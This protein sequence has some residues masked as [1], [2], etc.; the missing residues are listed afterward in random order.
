MFTATQA[1][2]AN[3]VCAALSLVILLTR[4][5]V[6]R[7]RRRPLDLS[8]F[9][10]I[11][12]IATIISR[13]VVVYYYLLYG[14]AND[15]LHDDGYFSTHNLAKVKTGTI[16]SL[17]ARVIIT[18]TCWLQI[19]LLLLFYSHIMEGIRWVERMI[20]VTWIVVGATFLA[21]V[22]TTL[23][24]CRPLKLYWQIEPDPGTC[25]KGYVQLNV[26]CSGNVVLDLLL[27]GISYPILICKHRTWQQHLRV[28]TLFVLG[29][30]CII[31]TSL[32][33]ALVYDNRSAQPT[34]SLWA[35][36]QMIVATFVANTPTIYG[37]LNVRKRKK[38]RPTIMRQNKP[39]SW[40]TIGDVAYSELAR[41]ERAASKGSEGS[42]RKEWFDQLEIMEEGPMKRQ[43]LFAQ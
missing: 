26:Q 39:E 5:I 14:T 27:L 38:S 2:H 36:V 8:F 33:L 35:S 28:G 20:K 17:V 4:A 22:L 11:L 42:T 7:L 37:D 31:V 32:R 3:Y 19:G 23:L 43:D 10:V 29:T 13:I 34:R 40:A 15:A 12:S 18:A 24:E 9:L 41:V 6:S 16:L 21:N 30:F 25:V 1:N